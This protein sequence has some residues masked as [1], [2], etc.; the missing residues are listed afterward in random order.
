MSDQLAE[1]APLSPEEILLF[2][3]IVES[4]V[5]TLSW[6][7]EARA[8]IAVTA[9]RP[10]LGKVFDDQ[11]K[12]KAV[13]IR[14][15]MSRGKRVRGLSPVYTQAMLEKHANVFTGWPMYMDH[16]PAELAEKV[17]RSGR[18]V[19]ELGGQVLTPWWQLDF[20]QEY[21]EQ[22]GY[23]KG[24]VLAEV[25]AN[26]FVRKLV[27]ENPD[28]LHTSISAW[29]TSGK[30]GPVPWAPK[31]KGMVI[32]G[33]RRQPQG[34][35]D[36]VPRGGAGG[37]VL[38]AEGE[39]ADT[40][41]WPE[42]RW[43]AAD[44]A[45]VVS[46]AESVYA[47]DAMTGTTTVPTPPTDPTQFGAWLREHAPHLAGAVQLQEAV[48]AI[49]PP[50]APAPAAQPGITMA[51][52][53]RMISEAQASAPDPSDAIEQK[54]REEFEDRDRE[55]REQRHL[56]EVAHEL[57]RV[58]E[59]VPE[60]WKADLRNRYAMLPE[61][62]SPALLVE[63]ETDDEG[64]TLT[65]ED[66]LKKRVAADLQKARDLIAEAQG[67]PRVTGEGGGSKKNAGDERVRE[68]AKETPYWREAFKDY[69]LVESVD[70]ALAIHGI[71]KKKV[72]G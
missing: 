30:P 61:G 65:E 8:P 71:E 69:G 66:V 11:G 60:S 29:P 62:P 49:T 54:L 43:D 21:D 68:Q 28:A 53:Q 5:W 56:S 35:V 42:P 72:E 7:Q 12:G 39:D 37:R 10:K 55:A 18:S 26:M 41:A 23:Q 32:E 58:A 40:A 4:A 34:S 70:N 46:V 16:V 2:G 1:D 13:L 22:F 31:K 63:S 15:C 64:A 20:V 38:L 3:P 24:G 67:K 9:G 6:V 44:L 57:I 59:G 33:I 52:V 14:P 36:F 25:W 45:L 47:S 51:D 19:K 50:A 27:G 48:P 17:A